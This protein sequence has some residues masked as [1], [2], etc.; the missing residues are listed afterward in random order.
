MTPASGHNVS[1]STWGGQQSSEL[2][3]SFQVKVML[4]LDLKL[5]PYCHGHTPS[6]D[7]V[8]EY[9]SSRAPDTDL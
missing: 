9:R 3:G 8:N 6:E 5:I 1:V 2:S 7:L 4:E